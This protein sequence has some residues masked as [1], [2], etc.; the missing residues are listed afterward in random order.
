MCS[1]KLLKKAVLKHFAT[2]TGTHLC[3]TLFLIK[4]NATYLKNIYKPLF[5]PFG[6]EAGCVCVCVCVGVCFLSAPFRDYPCSK[7]D[8]FS[9]KLIFLILLISSL[10]LFL[11][12]EYFFTPL[13]PIKGVNDEF[14]KF[15]GLNNG[16][17]D[18]A[19]EKMD[20]NATID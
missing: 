14:V 17:K 8:K 4:W 15:F 5:N 7:Y 6:R 16:N 10:P 13:T 11:L 1:L 9:E 18:I 3:W 20:N 2:F 12:I 19:P